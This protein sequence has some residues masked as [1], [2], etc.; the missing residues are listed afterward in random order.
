MI[1]LVAAS[2]ALSACGS[3]GTSELRVDS[4]D[5]RDG[6]PLADR[7]TCTG[8][9]AVPTLRW[10]GG[11]AGVAGW[12]VVVEDPDAPRDLHPLDRHRPR[13]H[14][15]VGRAPAPGGCR[16]RLGFLRPARLRRPCPPIGE[17]HRFRFR[18]HAPSEPLAMES[19]TPVVVARRRIEALSLDATELEVTYRTP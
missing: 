14:H 8:E 5:L 6:R 2:F 17:E 10:S 16:D 7:F 4:P 11:P 18:V 13:A 12:A 15:P 9:N 3:T 19:T 1:S